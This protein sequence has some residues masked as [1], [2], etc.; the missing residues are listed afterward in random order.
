MIR[1]PLVILALLG[2]ALLP[3][4]RVR[5]A[6]TSVSVTPASTTATLGTNNRVLLTWHVS[7]TL[8]SPIHSVQGQFTTYGGTSVQVLGTNGLMLNAA[9]PPSPASVGEALVIPTAVLQAAA[10]QGLTTIAYTRTFIDDDGLTAAGSG[11]LLINVV[12]PSL[13]TAT[14]FPSNTTATLQAGGRIHALW[15]VTANASGIGVRSTSG[16]FLLTLDGPVLQTVAQPIS[17]TVVGGTARIADDVQIP[18]SV[19]YQ[20]LAAHQSTFYF[21]RHFD[22]VAGGSGAD[23][24]VTIRIVGSNAGAL[25]LARVSLRFSDGSRRRVVGH[26][27]PLR[28]LAEIRYTGGGLLQAVWEVATPP[29]TSGQPVYRPL[30]FVRQYLLPGGQVLLESPPLPVGVSGRHV[31]RLRLQDPALDNGLLAL[32]YSVNPAMHGGASAP[33]ELPLRLP[34]NGASLQASTRFAWQ[35]VTGARAY[36]LEFYAADDMPGLQLPQGGMVVP[37][38][39]TQLRL[40]ELARAH[41]SSGRSYRWRVLA[42]GADG[43]MLAVSGLRELLVP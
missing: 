3:M 24:L 16:A 43:R 19:V 25:S 9:T 14:A 41:L 13:G 17:G 33:R 18:A 11:T 23:G 40:S 20:V 39:T 27:H 37:A 6:V 8:N 4:P 12:V 7:S 35:P 32:E 2:C 38:S 22:P 1:R 42:I 28:A 15:N 34:G 36:Q 21:H 29:S 31:V 30:R 10:N 26:D 5:A